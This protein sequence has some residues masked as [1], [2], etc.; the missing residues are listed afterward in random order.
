ME[1]LEATEAILRVIATFVKAPG[2]GEVIRMIDYQ[3]SVGEGDA[4]PILENPLKLYPALVEGADK[5]PR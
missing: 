5:N 2:S 1:P 3:Q 4:Q